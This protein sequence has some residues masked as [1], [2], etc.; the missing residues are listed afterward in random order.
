MIEQKK[1]LLSFQIS[2]YSI[3][4]P[5]RNQ[6]SSPSKKAPSRKMTLFYEAKFRYNPLNSALTI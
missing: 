6:V 5:A 3:S 4:L 1:N 2:V